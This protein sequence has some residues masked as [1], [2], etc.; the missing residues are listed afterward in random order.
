[1]LSGLLAETPPDLRSE[2]FLLSVGAML[3]VQRDIQRAQR[4]RFA[5]RWKSAS[6]LVDFWK[7]LSGALR[8]TE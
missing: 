1:M 6:E 8:D 7:S 5:R 4:E 2:E 3:Q